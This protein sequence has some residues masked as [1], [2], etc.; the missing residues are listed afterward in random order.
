MLLDVVLLLG[1]LPRLGRLRF[2][3]IG[4]FLPRGVWLGI[5]CVGDASRGGRGLGSIR[6]ALPLTRLYA[7]GGR[8]RGT[9]SG[10][11][12]LMFGS[13]SDEFFRYPF[14]QSFVSVKVVYV[15]VAGLITLDYMGEL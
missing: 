12:C 13:R 7:V 2:G 1:Q 8:R 6:A 14:V 3:S 15:G 4:G 10:G 9:H 11:S 5:G